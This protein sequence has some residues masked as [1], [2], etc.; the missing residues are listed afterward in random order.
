VS[1][2]QCSAEDLMEVIGSLTLRPASL[3]SL[4]MELCGLEAQLFSRFFSPLLQ[5][6]CPLAAFL[7]LQCVISSVQRS[8]WVAWVCSGLCCA[9]S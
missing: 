1:A 2:Q 6:G 9:C 4:L 7:S 3:H 8:L 5:H